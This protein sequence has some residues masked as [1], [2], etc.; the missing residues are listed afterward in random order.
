MK[1]S[2]ELIEVRGTKETIDFIQLGVHFEKD[3]EIVSTFVSCPLMSSLDPDADE[4]LMIHSALNAIGSG[5]L[6]KMR[7]EAEEQF[8]QLTSPIIHFSKRTNEVEKVY[9]QLALIE[10]DLWSD[11]RDYISTAN[12]KERV[13]FESSRIWKKTNPAVQSAMS[14]L[15][16]KQID[17]VFERAHQ[18]Q[19]E[20]NIR[21]VFE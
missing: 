12:E 3:N 5:D 14:G 21:D 20:S 16:S 17:D 11:F 19:K 7:R 10:M 18:L 9:V 4:D 1:E 15:T 8:N 13:Y 6:R 2:Y